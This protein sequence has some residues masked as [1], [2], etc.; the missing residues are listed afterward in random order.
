[1]K[2]FT[3]Q[4]KMT[5]DWQIGTGQGRGDLDSLV[6]RDGEN[7]PY[8][9][10]KTLTGILRDAC[11]L[12]A[13]GLDDGSASGLWHKWVN[14][15]FGEQPALA[16][17][18]IETSPRPAALAIRA[19]HL[20][21]TLRQ[22]LNARPR[23]KEA[24]VFIKPG[25]AINP[26]T[27]CAETD[28][29]RLEETVRQGAILEAKNC[30]LTLPPDA[31]KEAEKIA[32]A[33][34]LAGAKMLERLG[35]KRRRG[36]GKCEIKIQ[37]KIKADS[38]SYLSLIKTQKEPPIPPIFAEAGV[39]ISGVYA[40]LSDASWYS[41]TLE[42]RTESPVIIPAKTVGNVVETLDYIPGRYWLRLL[43]K[44][45]GGWID[46]NRGI[47]EGDI[48]V[49]NATI[50][51]A[52]NPSR[53]VPFALFAEKLGG[54][55]DKG[56]G[57]Y[58]RLEEAEPEGIQLKGIRKGY[59][60]TFDGKKWPPYQKVECLIYTHN[61]IE[62]RYQR[63]SSEVGG[64][65]SY[66]AISAKTEF[67]AELRL[68]KG[69]VD[70]LNRGKSNWWELLKDTYLIGQSK[71]DDYGVISV[72]AVSH[73]QELSNIN[74]RHENAETLT[75]WLLSDVLLR[76]DRLQ[77]TADLDT[78][79]KELEL[80]LEVSL[81][82]RKEKDKISAVARQ[83]RTDSW[84]VRWGIPRPSLVG[85]Q[86]GSCLVYKVVKGNLDVS[87]LSRVQIEG[88]G[89]R[90][91]EGYGQLCFNAPLLT[92]KLSE[93]YPEKAEQSHNSESDPE[94]KS[95]YPQLQPLKTNDIAFDYARIIEKEVWR[96]AMERKAKILAA[97]PQVRKR[98]LGIEIESEAGESK[99][100]PPMS[101]L[102]ALRS[103]LRRLQDAKDKEKVT[104]WIENLKQ[105]KNRKEKWASGS[106][107]TIERL[108]TNPQQVWREL[109]IGNDLTITSGGEQTLKSELWAEAVRTLVSAC[110]IAHKRAWE[111]TENIL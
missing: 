29:L 63:P 88:I 101:Q 35:G 1:M 38:H 100:I 104:G 24:L 43:H 10:A 99:S 69:L 58:N 90:R 64:V 61:T 33:L 25:I 76:G 97:D 77:V 83:R 52:G 107:E 56:K 14:C 26:V 34:L 109:Q 5:S 74:S 102:G 72:R 44:K 60:G 57:V 19:A 91:S 93:I 11:E 7:L 37:S 66:Q 31:S 42:I 47:R 4:I 32:Y 36:A 46:V 86:G 87:K 39:S 65:Y 8:I 49:T 108:I 89:E 106:L 15:L 2:E 53:P 59:I 6:Q 79:K 75:V 48:I 13:F 62:D 28:Y 27:G 80:A 103:V 92:A 70:Q 67:V 82:E 110:I 22:S 85:L 12:V 98:I 51:I 20:P 71:K 78:F 73:P 3:I 94:D 41:I 111:K 9:P 96:D 30:T 81:E 54:G 95:D 105:V 23:L 17:T 84:Q 68:K 45:L 18:A 21:K 40:S 50:K 16:E 55:L